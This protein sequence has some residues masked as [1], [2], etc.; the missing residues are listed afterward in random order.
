MP[1]HMLSIILNL[2]EGLRSRR[3]K[4][5]LSEGVIYNGACYMFAET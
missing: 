4:H 1:L 5:N 2:K 3:L